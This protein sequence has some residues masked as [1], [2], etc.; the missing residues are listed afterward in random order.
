[1]IQR[2]QTIYL[3]LIIV[4]SFFMFSGNII[5]AENQN[6]A[7]VN[8]K[9]SENGHEFLAG[10]STQ[11]INLTIAISQKITIAIILLSSISVF[12]YKK[13]K[14]QNILTVFI[15]VLSVILILAMSY[16]IFVVS[17]ILSNKI[18]PGIRTF[19]PPVLLLLAILAARGIRHDENLI[20]SYERL[21]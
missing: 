18:I 19:I 12:L 5:V 21:R 4:L 8:F 17:E 3:V 14:I 15:A 7:V 2:I 13:R 9:F 20:K 16:L 1:M 6:G 10:Q 11:K